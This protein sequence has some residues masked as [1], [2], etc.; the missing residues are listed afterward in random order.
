MKN[1]DELIAN[2]AD[3]K[4]FV[5]LLTNLAN[6]DIML[7]RRWV[8]MERFDEMLEELEKSYSNFMKAYNKN[9][10]TSELLDSAEASLQRYQEFFREI[11]SNHI[12]RKKHNQFAEILDEFD[13]LIC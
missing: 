6:Y 4:V 3:L 5:K 7:M 1:I 2:L 12:S 8:F 11:S 13:F 10:V 9:K